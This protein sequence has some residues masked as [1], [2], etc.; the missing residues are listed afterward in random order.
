MSDQNCILSH[1]FILLNFKFVK[2][3]CNNSISSGICY[4]Y[5]SHLFEYEY[6]DAVRVST[7]HCLVM[8]G[9][10]NLSTGQHQFLNIITTFAH[11][12]QKTFTHYINVLT[13]KMLNFA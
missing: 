6:M 1:D 5:Q 12:F 3:V 2:L 10:T 9:F 11:V 7:D 8:T 13:Q 4:W